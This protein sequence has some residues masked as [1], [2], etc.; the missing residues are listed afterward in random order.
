MGCYKGRVKFPCKDC[1]DR[2][3]NC[4]SS[5]E[6]YKKSKAEVEEISKKRNKEND[7]R[8]AHIQNVMR[9]KRAARSG[10]CGNQVFKDY[11]K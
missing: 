5:C 8:D 6:E 9:V 11:M 2:K 4:H 1:T 7:L 10:N 3:L